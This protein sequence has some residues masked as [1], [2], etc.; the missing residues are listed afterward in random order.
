MN[1]DG[2]AVDDVYDITRYVRPVTVRSDLVP[3][4]LEAY[5]NGKSV[6]LTADQ[7]AAV[8]GV[9]GEG[10]LF[11][12]DDLGWQENVPGKGRKVLARRH[13]DAVTYYRFKS[14]WQFQPADR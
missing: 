14:H 9:V 1:F 3:W 5:T 7:V 10:T 4:P 8:A 2:Q 6:F 12:S 11:T 13:I